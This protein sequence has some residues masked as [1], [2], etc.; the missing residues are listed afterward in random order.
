MIKKIFKKLIFFLYILYN[1]NYYFRVAKSQNNNKENIFIKKLSKIVPNKNFIEIGF[2]NTEFNCVGLIE[3][4]FTG[5]LIDSGRMLNIIIMRIILFIIGKSNIEVKDIHVEKKNLKKILKKIKNIG[6]VS[7]DIDGNDFWIIKKI[8]DLKLK[9]NVFI[10]EYNPSLL[11]FPYTV[12]YDRFFDRFKKHESGLYHGASL[13]A[14]HKILKKNGYSLVR[15]IGGLN[16]VFLDNKLVKK[17]KLKILNPK[18]AYN[19]GKIRNK[20][21]KK[22]AKQQFEEI[23]NLKFVKV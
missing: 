7:I 4:N 9:P 2:H 22:N 1:Q 19:E 23:K 13:I 6:F 10:V 16:A 17:T 5:T 8:L 3:K 15:V 11:N 18:E 21:Y 14:F 20:Y 12:P